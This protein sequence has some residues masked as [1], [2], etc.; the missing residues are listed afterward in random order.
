MGSGRSIDGAS[1]TPRPSR[2]APHRFAHWSESVVAYGGGR[3]AARTLQT[4]QLLGLAGGEEIDVVTVHRD[5][6]EADAIVHLA[7]ELLAAHEAP[8]RLRPIAS[9][10]APA[11]VL[12]DEVHR[13]R[14]RLLVDGSPWS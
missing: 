14:P 10:V 11:E 6:A 5:R 9:D 2:P 4:F 7:G 3:E 1:R 13:R 12:L 8:H